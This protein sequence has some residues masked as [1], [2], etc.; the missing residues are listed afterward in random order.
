MGLDEGDIAV[1]ADPL[2]SSRLDRSASAKPLEPWF[3]GF[4]I[5]LKIGISRV[6]YNRSSI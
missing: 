2:C 5:S 1:V 6:R 4:S 3:P